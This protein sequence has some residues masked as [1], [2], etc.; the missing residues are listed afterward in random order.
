MAYD[1]NEDA[2]KRLVIAGVAGLVAFILCI[3]IIDFSFFWSLVWG[4]IVGAAVY[5]LLAMRE[6]AASAGSGGGQALAKPAPKPAPKPA[7]EPAA[8]PAAAPADPGV[9]AAGAAVEP[10]APAASAADIPAPAP[11]SAG[12]GGAGE[13]VK[14]SKPLAGQEELAARKGSW[15][16][17]GGEAAPAAPAARPAAAKA[18]K[19][20]DAAG[21]GTRPE[22]LEGPRAGGPDNLKEIRGV[23]PKLEQLLHGLGIYHFDQVANWT[24]DEVAWVDANLKGFKGR[25]SRDGWVEQARILAA[26][27]ETE[28]SKRVDKGDVY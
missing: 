24:A 22:M 17:G 28:F 1:G 8:K 16:Y 3:W 19:G 27:G 25:V 18:G 2:N 6:D 10:A 11:D 26:G 23:G 9:A 4:V 13:T 15:T 5:F 7:A 20:D 21:A 14:R 12:T